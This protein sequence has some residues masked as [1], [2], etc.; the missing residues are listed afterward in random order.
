MY[1][2]KGWS[3]KAAVAGFAAYAVGAAGFE[4]AM[5]FA[6][7]VRPLFRRESRQQHRCSEADLSLTPPT[8]QRVEH[9]GS[10]GLTMTWGI[11]SD[12]FLAIGFAPQFYEI[13]KA[14][15]VIGLSYLFLFMDSL[16]AV[17]SL[18]SLACKD[19][20]DIIAL[21]GYV[22]VLGLEIVIVL[23][24]LVL[25][26]RARRARM[27]DGVD[28]GEGEGQGEKGFPSAQ[29]TLVCE[30][31]PTLK[32]G[33]LEAAPPAAAPPA[34]AANDDSIAAEQPPKLPVVPV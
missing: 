1:Y 12:I 16:G 4:I 11:L 21:V 27:R 2:D 9:I 18:V 8:S 30:E 10:D 6:S 3:W 29:P 31:A 23:L 32:C 5:V 25:N 22:A 19:V 34:A 14:Q 7:R 15:E 24:A 33:N 20:L 13:Y 17:F 26:P 28:E